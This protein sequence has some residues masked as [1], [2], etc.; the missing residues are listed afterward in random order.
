MKGILKNFMYVSNI[1]AWI[2]SPLMFDLVKKIK[3]VVNLH[4][5][6]VLKTHPF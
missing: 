5:L 6:W 4:Y 1:L 3:Y 2:N